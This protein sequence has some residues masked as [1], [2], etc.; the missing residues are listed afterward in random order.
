MET[1]YDVGQKLMKALIDQNISGDVIS[2]D[3]SNGKVT[4]LGKSFLRA[5]EFQLTSSETNFVHVPGEVL[6]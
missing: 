5:N 4:K 1:T 2:T 6:K 3:K